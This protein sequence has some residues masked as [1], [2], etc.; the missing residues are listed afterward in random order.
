MIGMGDPSNAGLR[1][2]DMAL[3]PKAQGLNSRGSIHLSVI[4]SKTKE[5]AVEFA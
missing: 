4:D 1:L 3:S 2:A 5:N